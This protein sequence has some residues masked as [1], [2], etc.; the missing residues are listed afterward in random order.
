MPDQA[1]AVLEHKRPADSSMR[2]HPRAGGGPWTLLFW[3]LSMVPGTE[4]MDRQPCVY[5]LASGRNGTLYCGVTSDLVQRVWEH[6][7]HLASGFTDRYEVTRLVW[8]EQH[9][10]ME[11]AIAREKR[12]KRWNRAWKLRLIDAMNPSWRDLWPDITGAIPNASVHG[13]PPA[14]G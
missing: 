11:S 6:R 14:R 1:A 13:P 9:A 4:R 7:E 10:T 3:N 8:Y 2:R 5:L 12:I